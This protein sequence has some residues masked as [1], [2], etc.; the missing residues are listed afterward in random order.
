MANV[1]R[2][3]GNYLWA[4]Q[5][6]G[7]AVAPAK[8]NYLRAQITLVNAYNEVENTLKPQANNVKQQRA[9]EAQRIKDARHWEAQ[10][11]GKSVDQIKEEQGDDE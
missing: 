2:M 10:M 5:T 7:N 9:R 1:M 3:I 6:N 11:T 8:Q 4:L